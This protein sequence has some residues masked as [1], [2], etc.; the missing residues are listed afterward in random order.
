MLTF[1]FFQ[2]TRARPPFVRAHIVESDERAS[3]T[4]LLLGIPCSIDIFSK[5][6]LP[7]KNNPSPLVP[8]KSWPECFVRQ[9]TE[10]EEK[11]L[12]LFLIYVWCFISFGDSGLEMSSSYSPL[13]SLPIQRVDF[14][15]KNEDA[16]AGSDCDKSLFFL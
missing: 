5:P 13:S 1:L 8:T 11:D 12:G 14:S 7:Y 15:K 3:E 4:M 6:P 9:E 16:P 10:F 2:S